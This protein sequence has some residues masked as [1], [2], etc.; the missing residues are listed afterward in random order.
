MAREPGTDT[1]PRS[2]LQFSSPSPGGLCRQPRPGTAITELV[3]NLKDAR[4]PQARSVRG[5]ARRD[6]GAGPEARRWSSG[7]PGWELRRSPS[8]PTPPRSPHPRRR[9]CRQ[10]LGGGERLVQSFFLPVGSGLG[11][12]VCRGLDCGRGR[13]EEAAVRSKVAQSSRLEERPR[14]C[15]R[16]AFRSVSAISG[17]GSTLPHGP[18]RVLPGTRPGWFSLTSAAHETAVFV[19]NVT[20]ARPWASSPPVLGS[21]SVGRICCFVDLS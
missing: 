4:R 8:H 10:L 17:R 18:P 1:A 20:V 5:A 9:S 13:A 19:S 2:S 15:S 21:S 7:V 3:R 16:D 11:A 6:P 12:G 14:A